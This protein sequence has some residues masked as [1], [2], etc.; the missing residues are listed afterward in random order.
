MSDRYRKGV[1]GPVRP[2]G[3]FG[4]GICT[5]PKSDFPLSPAFDGCDDVASW[6]F[7]IADTVQSFLKKEPIELFGDVK[8]LGGASVLLDA[9]HEY[10]THL[11]DPSNMLSA[12]SSDILGDTW[13]VEGRLGLA[14]VAPYLAIAALVIDPSL[15]A[16][17]REGIMDF[18]GEAG[19]WFVLEF[20][21]QFHTDKE[22]IAWLLQ[23]ASEGAQPGSPTSL[24]SPHR[25]DAHRRS[26]RSVGPSAKVPQH[27]NT[28]Q[29]IAQRS[30][31]SPRGLRVESIT[32]PALPSKILVL[33]T[34][35][36][37]S[38][39]LHGVE[40]APEKYRE[41]TEEGGK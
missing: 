29:G 11:P 27:L 35:S 24:S 37:P 5:G 10:R 23:V 3:E 8:L 20:I 36:S 25:A 28:S 12:R 19:R 33:N 40:R 4:C 34:P 14:A 13:A 1:W 9:V 39:N 31:G 18:A 41:T 16:M 30:P 32:D 2:V 22:A 17:H 7:G 26:G 6:A 38:E 21:R 15:H